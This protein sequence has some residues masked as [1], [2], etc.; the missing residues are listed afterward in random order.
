MSMPGVREAYDGSASSW[1]R[2]P[3]A[4]YA[5]LADA[6]L[7]VCPVDLAGARVLDVGAGTAV[8]ARA[9]LERG[10]TSAV[11]T[12]I[13]A[14][15]LAGRP[16]SV[17]GVLADGARLPFPDATFDLV[18]A[19]FCL[20]H[21]PDPASAMGEIHRVGSAVVASA[22]APGPGH[23]VKAAVDEVFARVGFTTPRWYQHQKDVLEPR[24]EDPEALRALARAAGFGEVEVH[25]LEV[26]TGL[27]SPAAVVDWRL[28]M[29]HLAP[30]VAG[31]PPDVLRRARGEA[32]A[33]VGAMLP[34][35]IPILALSAS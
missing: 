18:T 27:D 6:L 19:A 29:A 25:R 15:M 13:A 9:A 32:E 22:F 26:D 28:G 20:G 10:A 34:V 12:D 2:G 1:R 24:V 33:A 35:V 7:S 14:Q 8:A 17:H 30:F 21:L 16:A 4:V 31:L 3:E 5:R 11:A 23:P